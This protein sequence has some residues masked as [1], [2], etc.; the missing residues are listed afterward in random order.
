MP[1]FSSNLEQS[2]HRALAIA[3]RHNHEFTTVEHLLYSLIEDPDA[4]HV[5]NACSVDTSLLKNSIEKFFLN[6][7]N[8]L[9]VD[10][11]ENSK[12]TS[13]LQ[14]VIQRALIHVQ[15]SGKEEVTGANILV[16][17][18]SERDSFAV[19]FLK[20]QNVSRLDIV[21]F[22][23]HGDSKINYEDAN[24][25]EQDNNPDTEDENTSPKKQLTALEKYCFNLNEKANRGNG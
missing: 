9:V 10:S 23:S 2:L 20:K 22:L 7:L 16:A 4:L 8:N 19:Y 25:I 12:P 13:G 14:R 6:E 17:L 3:N 11:G 21:S 1:S 18:F 5:L 15:S 24:D